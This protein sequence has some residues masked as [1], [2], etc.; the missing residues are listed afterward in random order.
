MYSTY[1]TAGTFYFASDTA[2]PNDTGFPYS[3]ALTGAAFA[4]GT[5]NKKQVNHARYSTYEGFIQDTWKVSRR[6][7]LDIGIRLQSIG[8]ERSEGATLGLFA[9]S[10]FNSQKVGQLLFPAL[11]S[12]GK[13]VAINPTNGVTYPY[14]QVGTFDPASYPSTGFPWSGVVNYQTNFWNRGEPNIGPRIGFAYDALGNGKLAIRGGFGA[15]YGRATSVDNIAAAGAG[16]GPLAVAPNFLAPAYVYPTFST[17]ASSQ[18]YYGPQAVFGGSQDIKNPQTLQWSFGVQRDVGK[19]TI[20]DVSYLGWV[21]HHGFNLTGYDYNNVAPYTTW[22]PTPGP[23]TNSCGMVTAYLDPTASAVNPTNCSGG[24]FLSSNLIRALNGYPGW[25]S[26]SVSTNAGESNYNALQV[27]INKRF[28]KR[29]QFGTNYNWSKQLAYSRTQDLPDILTYNVASGN[30][31][32]VVNINFGY[33][34]PDGTT[35]IPK[36]WFTSGVFDG[37]NINGVLSFYNGLPMTV[38]CPSPGATG[39]VTNSPIGWWSRYACQRSWNALPDEQHYVPARRVHARFGW[40]YSRS[41]AVVS[42]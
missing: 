41:A 8:Q 20:L 35:F 42:I 11:N 18:A 15:F 33:R 9:A 23:G 31:P 14:A 36:N 1:N 27:Q 24:A 25:T 34:V 32:Q 7:T 2:N 22:K 30:R 29:L 26:I 3:N 6:L 13:K 28:G 39:G 4:Y 21:T 38:S 37:W 5:D 40:L 17:L 10:A 19:G 12:A 16:N